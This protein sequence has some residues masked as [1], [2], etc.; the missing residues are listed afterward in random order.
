MISRFVPHAPSLCVRPAPSLRYPRAAMT[1]T[2][3]TWLAAAWCASL[4][5]LL[6]ITML[7]R[8]FG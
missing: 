7:T 4:S 6:L 1:R 2:T 3:F 5:G 8:L